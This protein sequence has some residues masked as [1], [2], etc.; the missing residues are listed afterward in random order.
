MYILDDN[1][2]MKRLIVFY[3]HKKN[4]DLVYNALKELELKGTVPDYER[5]IRFVEDTWKDSKKRNY[6]RT[7]DAAFIYAYISKELSYLSGEIIRPDMFEEIMLYIS[8]IG[9]LFYKEDFERDLYI[10]KI[11]INDS[12]FG[13]CRF[14]SGHLDAYEL[15]EYDIDQY[16][17]SK[18]LVLPRLCFLNNRFDYPV[19]TKK[20]DSGEKLIRAVTPFTICSIEDYITKSLGDVLVLG[21]GLGY[22][23]YQISMKKTVKSVT[24]VEK[25]KNIIDLFE[26]A[27]LP[28]FK[29]AKKINIIN[30]DPFDYIN[31]LEDAKY[32]HC[33]VDIWDDDNDIESYF[34]MKALCKRFKKTKFF[35]YLEE[36]FLI[37]IREQVFAE[38]MKEGNSV[39]EGSLPKMELAK[40]WGDDMP[41]SKMYLQ[42]VYDKIKINNPPSLIS[43]CEPKY[44]LQYINKAKL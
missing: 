29:N 13:D 16:N 4:G 41:Y 39:F 25:D 37:R 10:S 28:Q 11:K 9:F 1:E 27:I 7:Q 20:T 33:F 21:C 30:A 18:E 38:V 14:T 22:Y 36:N 12:S 23:T 19:I 17:Y 44:I 2:I 6:Y 31:K 3:N 40:P 8:F 42:K 35:F 26:N 32:R 34:K 5:M 15:T 24:I 43:Y